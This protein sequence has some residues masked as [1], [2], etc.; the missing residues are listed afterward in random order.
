MIIVIAAAYA[1]L[2]GG[3]ELGRIPMC[4]IQFDK[5]SIQS[6]F[7]GRNDIDSPLQIE[8]FCRSQTWFANSVVDLDPVR[9]GSDPAL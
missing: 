1:T 2:K 8:K 9:S 6:K 7:D 5:Y 4:N 3:G